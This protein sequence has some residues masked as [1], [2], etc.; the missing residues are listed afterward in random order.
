M[1][2]YGEGVGCFNLGWTQS[3]P[4]SGSGCFLSNRS[5]Y[6]L[7]IAR[8]LN[9][10][11]KTLAQGLIL[12]TTPHAP[13]PGHSSPALGPVIQAGW[14]WSIPQPAWGIH[15]ILYLDVILCTNTIFELRSLA[16]ELQHGDLCLAQVGAA[17]VPEAAGVLEVG[18]EMDVEELRGD[19]QKYVNSENKRIN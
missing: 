16:V 14:Q 18:A 2:N 5:Q 3:H 9:K 6:R 1:R 13:S 4:L 10:D 8:T 17:L 15:I 12:L 7:N 19:L 11:Q